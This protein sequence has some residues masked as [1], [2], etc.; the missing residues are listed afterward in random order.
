VHS[1]FKHHKDKKGH[2]P[3]VFLEW[4][5]YLKSILAEVSLTAKAPHCYQPRGSPEVWAIP[6][7]DYLR[8]DNLYNSRTQKNISG[9]LI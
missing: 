5:E 9:L 2:N 4:Q 3:C 6:G 8:K 1:V 7:I